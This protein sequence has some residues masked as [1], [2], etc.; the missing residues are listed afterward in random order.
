[1][2]T[3]P[4]RPQQTV[5]NS[6]QGS[7]CLEG[8]NLSQNFSNETVHSPPLALLP[9][10]LEEKV[11]PAEYGKGVGPQGCYGLKGENSS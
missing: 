7:Y 10:K 8:G 2:R 4:M 11:S 3:K 6:L 1:M 9:L 5:G